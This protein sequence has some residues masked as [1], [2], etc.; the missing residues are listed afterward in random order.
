MQMQA[1]NKGT[2]GLEKLVG[3]GRSWW[4]KGV[5]GK[6][7]TCQHVVT[8]TDGSSRLCLRVEHCLMSGFLPMC[9]S[10]REDPDGGFVGRR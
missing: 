7:A 6:L 5:V 8:V 10:V 9:R 3:A 4:E 1:L 2:S